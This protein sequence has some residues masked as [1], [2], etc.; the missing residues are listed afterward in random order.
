[1]DFHFFCVEWSYGNINSHRSAARTNAREQGRRNYPCDLSLDLSWCHSDGSFPGT[2]LSWHLINPIGTSSSSS[3]W[4]SKPGCQVWFWIAS[5]TLVLI[6]LANVQS[7]LHAEDCYP[8]DCL[9]LKML[10]WGV[11]AWGRD[12]DSFCYLWRNNLKCITKW[13]GRYE[14][15]RKWNRVSPS[16]E[17]NTCRTLRWPKKL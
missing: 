8:S 12:S 10:G 11:A 7:P 13:H 17:K 6:W 3:S 5:Q 14:S 9:S 16:A 1:M 15:N 2:G 4:E